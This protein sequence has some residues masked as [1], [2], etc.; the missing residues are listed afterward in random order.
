M[1]LFTA[2]AQAVSNAASLAY[3]I[4][5]D[6][7]LTGAQR[8][9]NEFSSREAAIARQF[10]ASQAEQQMAFQER[11]ANSQYQRAVLDMQAAGVNPALAYSQGGNVAPSG[12]AASA[13]G[14]PSSVDP[15]RGISM[16]DMVQLLSLPALLK[17]SEAE[18]QEIQTRSEMNRASTEMTQAELRVFQPRTDLELANLRSDL[19]SKEV[20]RDLKRSGISVNEAEAA[21]KSNEAILSGIDTKYR[22]E[23]NA[24]E[25]KIRIANLGLIGVQSKE[26]LKRI[27]LYDAQIV[28]VLQRAIT[29]AAQANLFDEESRSQLIHQHILEYDE[30]SKEFQVS[31]QALTYTLD[32]I[33]KV[34]GAISS[35]ATT[36][37]AVGVGTRAMI[38][39]PLSAANKFNGSLLSKSHEFD[40]LI[41]G[42]LFK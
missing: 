25:N 33:G 16:S 5:K 41:N 26:T 10:N 19:K 2:I 23:L 32:S 37:A 38:G 28:E 6:Q 9:A 4:S 12:S 7:H 34:F 1:G 27:E 31:K 21:L 11:M 17:K 29:E 3:Q 39:S 15:G 22:D 36:Y 42:S 14:S 30:K 20:E 13:S 35:A 24:L 18:T 8:E 40:P